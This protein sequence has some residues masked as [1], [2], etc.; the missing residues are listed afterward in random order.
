MRKKHEAILLE[1]LDI[2]NFLG[3]SSTKLDYKASLFFL[4]REMK[5]KKDINSIFLEVC[6][7]KDDSDKEAQDDVAAIK[8]ILRNYLSSKKNLILELSD[9]RF[10]RLI[11]QVSVK[12]SYS[13][14]GRLVEA[15]DDPNMNKAAIDLMNIVNSE[16]VQEIS[17]WDAFELMGDI[18]ASNQYDKVVETKE[19]EEILG[20]VRSSMFDL[21]DSI[22]C[23]DKELQFLAELDSKDREFITFF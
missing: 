6:N 8:K 21:L 5:D 7:Y 12:S 2:V 17:E 14:I 18:N 3:L 9:W 23:P 16:L 1:E 20:K 4:Y 13:D 11:D 10:L 22:V 15:L 19:Y